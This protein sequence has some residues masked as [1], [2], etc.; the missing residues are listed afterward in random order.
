[1]T[2]VDGSGGWRS[3]G[4]SALVAVL[5]LCRQ[6][7]VARRVGCHRSVISRLASGRV[8][9]PDLRVAKLLEDVFGVSM[10]SWLSPVE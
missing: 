8:Q 5:Q 7:E 3:R 9:F 1:M 4:R 10:G 6:E 2:R